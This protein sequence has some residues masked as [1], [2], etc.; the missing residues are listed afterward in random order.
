[1]AGSLAGLSTGINL[2][3]IPE[4]KLPL[5][6]RI[7]DLN[8]GHLPRIRPHIPQCDLNHTAGLP[9]SQ[10]PDAGGIEDIYM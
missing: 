6:I 5:C 9:K 10:T 1:M 4:S 8:S 2:I 7:Q 3:N